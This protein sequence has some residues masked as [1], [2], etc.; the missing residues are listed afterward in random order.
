MSEIIQF[1]Y[2]GEDYKYNPQNGELYYNN[3]IY[4]SADYDKHFT[5]FLELQYLIIYLIGNGAGYYSFT[6]DYYYEIDGYK[7]IV[8][9]P[10]AFTKVIDLNLVKLDIRDIR[11]I[12]SIIND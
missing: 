6:D 11:D 1:T 7:K 5:Y 12:Y 4:L 9:P 10:S 8:S 3:V 2:D